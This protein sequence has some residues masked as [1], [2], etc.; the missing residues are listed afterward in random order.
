L[1][2][3]EVSESIDLKRSPGIEQ[4]SLLFRGPRAPFYPQGIYTL[5]HEKLGKGELFIVP[6]GPDSQGMCYQVVLSRSEK[7]CS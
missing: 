1:E 6:V 4:F 2:L 3:L 5:A 7:A